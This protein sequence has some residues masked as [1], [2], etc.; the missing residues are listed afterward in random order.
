MAVTS[1]KGIEMKDT[2]YFM[3]LVSVIAA[4]FFM[5]I[6]APIDVV[7]LFLLLAILSGQVAGYFK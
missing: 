3:M 6:S 5:I 2:L 1:N 7:Q 4:V